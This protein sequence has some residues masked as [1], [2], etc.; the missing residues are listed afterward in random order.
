MFKALNMQTTEIE[1]RKEGKAKDKQK[2]EKK[3]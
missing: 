1:Y 2:K 3:K